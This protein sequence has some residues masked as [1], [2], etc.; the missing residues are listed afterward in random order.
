MLANTPTGK[1]NLLKGAI[2]AAAFVAIGARLIWPD[3]KID[4]LTLG[5]LI[6]AALPWL[7]P[8]V[9]SAEFPG[10]WKVEFRDIAGAVRSA[11]EVPRPS[12]E[13][14]HGEDDVFTHYFVVGDRKQSPPIY[15]DLVEQDPNLAMVALRI[16]IEKKARALAELHHVPTD[17][18][19]RRLLVEL[20]KKKVLEPSI[21]NGLDELVS[22]GNDAAHGKEVGRPIAERAIEAANTL[23]YYLDR[24]IARFGSPLEQPPSGGV[25]E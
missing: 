8:L 24:K 9:K 7:L 12:S 22:V 2:T 15:F 10:G 21:S 18:P 5:L 4:A 14:G 25:P 3:L 19:L 13:R 23:I 6:L 20:Q 11:A 17:L 1:V 16:E